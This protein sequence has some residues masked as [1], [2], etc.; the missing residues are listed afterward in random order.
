M[1]SFLIEI[2]KSGIK[3][4]EQEG[5]Q[6]ISGSLDTAELSFEKRKERERGRERSKTDFL[7][8]CF[9]LPLSSPEKTNMV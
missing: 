2:V 8:T 1:C 4:G 7:K 9:S 5:S 3:W 6:T